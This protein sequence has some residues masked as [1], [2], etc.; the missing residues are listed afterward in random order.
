MT[1]FNINNFRLFLKVLVT[2]WVPIAVAAGLDF[3]S[4]LSAVAVMAASTL[5]I[6]A[7]FRV[8]GVGDEAPV[9]RP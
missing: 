6:D 5:T 4:Q 9:T 3:G 1:K 8:F 7:L 2:A